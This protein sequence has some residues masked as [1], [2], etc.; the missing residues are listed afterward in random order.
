MNTYIPVK[1]PPLAFLMKSMLLLILFGCCSF[2]RLTAQA[3]QRLK[4]ADILQS[5]MVIQQN[6][7]FKIWGNASPGAA[8]IIEADWSK[9]VKVKADEQGNFLTKINVPK[10]VKG[11]FTTH[12]I[13]ITSDKEEVSISNMLIGEVWICSGQSNMQ[14]KLAEDKNAATELQK[15]DH[16]NIRLFNAALNF[17]NSP[18][19]TIKGKWQACTPETVKD[20]SAVGYYFAK[21]LQNRLN[22]PIGVIFSGIGASKA[23]AFIP[24]EVLAANPLLDSAYLKPYLN[25][26]KSKE[27][28]DGGFS[29]EKVMRPYL[30]YNAMINPLIN[31][32]VKGFC[33]Y[34]GESNRNERNIYT[35]A[36][37]TLI[38]S[39]RERFAQGELPFY[40]VQVAPYFYDQEDPKLNDYAFFRESQERISSLKNTAMVVSMDVGEAKDLHPKQKGPLGVRLART[41]LNLTY[42]IDTVD[43]KGPQYKSMKIKG[44]TVIISFDKTSVKSGLNTN[45]GQIPKYFTIAGADRVFYPAIAK[46][47]G[48]NIILSSDEV[49]N[50]AAVRYAFTNYPVTNLQNIKGLP[51]VPFRT[52]NW[53]E[54]R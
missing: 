36:T 33:W 4:L 19:Q 26:P 22:I 18:L 45:D 28:V 25:S 48:N 6:K 46:I 42:G 37:Q 52:D 50:P 39:W 1:N 40:Y 31:L 11:D 43:W 44:S 9:P 35:L 5:N 3:Q 41:S 14:F 15:A 51:A 32:S 53:P 12:T 7:A 54:K 23:E 8:L 13:R 10:A 17:S 24:Q 21:T 38:R 27:V 30:L 16:P 20:F 29:F 47:D 34:Q 2:S 49:K